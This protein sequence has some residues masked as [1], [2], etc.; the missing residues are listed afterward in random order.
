MRHTKV[1]HLDDIIREEEDVL[2][3]DVAV[4]NVVVMQELDGKEQLAEEE[5]APP[6]IV[7]GGLLVHAHEGPWWRSQAA[8]IKISTKSLW[9]VSMDERG[10]SSTLM[11]RALHINIHINETSQSRTQA[12]R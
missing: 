12:D 10:E 1:C 9:H 5:A 2:G 6:L 7:W 11:Q 8:P 3:L 4:D